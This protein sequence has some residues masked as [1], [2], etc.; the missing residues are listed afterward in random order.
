MA[1]SGRED[2]MKSCFGGVVHMLSGKK[3]PQN[4]RALRLVTEKLLRAHLEGCESHKNMLKELESISLRSI[5]TH[6]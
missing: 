3:F 2:I 6:L 4:F 5:T 1:D